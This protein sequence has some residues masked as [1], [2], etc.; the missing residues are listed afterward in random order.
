MASSIVHHLEPS[1]DSVGHLSKID[2]LCECIIW[3]PKGCKHLVRTA[4]AKRV[5]RVFGALPQACAYSFLDAVFWDDDKQGISIS[6]STI[7][8][9]HQTPST[10]A[11]RDVVEFCSGIGVM[12]YGLEQAGAKIQVRN[13]IRSPLVEFQLNEGTKHVIEGDIGDNRT[14]QKIFDIHS[15]SA[16]LTCGFSC[17]PWSALG[18]QRKFG[19]HRAQTLI[20]T[21]RAAYF[22]RSAGVILEC[23]TGSGKDPDVQQ[24]IRDWC[25]ATGFWFTDCVLNLE[26]FWVARRERWWCLLSSPCIP[27][28]E[29]KSLPRQIRAPV[30]ADFLPIF[31]SWPDEQLQQ[32]LVDEYEYGCFDRFGGLH[33]VLIDLHK[34]LS[35]ALHGWGNQLTGCPCSCRKGPMSLQRLSSK[36]L[37]GALL[38]CDGTMTVQNEKV[39]CVRHIHPWECAILNGAKPDRP[40]LI[41]LKLGLCGLGQMAS[42][43]HSG[44]VF[45][46]W[47][48]QV[49][50]TWNEPDAILPEQVL[51]AL[52]GKAVSARE[53]MFPHLL[54]TK[55][56]PR[57]SEFI[58]ATHRMLFQSRS[59]TNTPLS[60][61]QPSISP[62]EIP[63]QQL[64]HDESV[65]S[66]TIVDD[67]YGDVEDW[68]C[69]Y[70]LCFICRPFVGDTGLEDQ[71]HS[72]LIDAIQGS[73]QDEISPTIPFVVH[74][75]TPETLLPAISEE[76]GI[77]G[78]SRKRDHASAFPSDTH[79]DTPQSSIVSKAPVK[80]TYNPDPPK[81]N[82][83]S[84]A[85]PVP[86]SFTHSQPVLPG[87]PA[88][89]PTADPEPTD[90]SA[91]AEISDNESPPSIEG[92]SC[93]TGSM[94]NCKMIQLLEQLPKHGDITDSGDDCTHD[95]HHV[96]MHFPDVSNPLIVKVS[97][98]TTI[99][100]IVV[101]QCSLAQMQDTARSVRVMDCLGQLLPWSKTSYPMQHIF[102]CPTSNYRPHGCFQ[103]SGP[104][105]WFRHGDQ[106][107]R[108]QMLYR[109][110]SWVAHDEMSF[111][112][113]LL[114]YQNEC[115]SHAPLVFTGLPGQFHQWVSNCLGI[116]VEWVV[117]AIL[118]DHHWI[119]VVFQKTHDDAIQ[120]FTTREGFQLFRC[121]YQIPDKMQVQVITMPSLFSADCGFQTVGWILKI[122]TVPEVRFR[123][124]IV[125]S[126]ISPLTIKEAVTLRT[127]FEH[128]LWATPSAQQ[129]V[130]PKQ[131]ALGGALRESVEQSLQ[132]LLK[133][134][135]VPSDAL[136]SRVEVVL[137]KLG[138][139]SVSKAVR[140]AKSWAELKHLANNV[141]PR[142]QLVL[143]SELA[144]VVRERVEKGKPFGDKQRKHQVGSKASEPLQLNPEDI[145]IPEGIFK[146]GQDQVIR[147]IA[148]GSLCKD[149]QGIVVVTSTQAQPYLRLQQPMS[150]AGLAMLI[151][152]HADPSCIGSGCLVR[153]PAKFEST[154]EPLIATARIVQLGC[155]EIS[156]HLP[157]QQLKVDEVP[158]SVIRVLCFRDEFPGEWNDFIGHPVKF[159]MDNTEAF[160]TKTASESTVIDVWD[161]Q[162]VNHRMERRQPKH[163]DTFLVSI[164][165]TGIQIES[166]LTKSGQM[167]LYYEPRSSDGRSPHES[168]RVV[169]L[170]KTAKPDAL[171]SQQTSE[172]WSCLARNG[173][174]FGLRIRDV[175]AKE[176]HD[177]YKP[178]VPYLDGTSLNTF[179]VG[180][181]GFGVTKQGLVKLFAQWKW[182]ARPCQPRGKSTDG[183][184][185]L[186]E[187][188]AQERPAFE[189]YTLEHGDVLIS[190]V[191]KKK[192][193]VKPKSDI[194]APTR[195]L[196]VL[197][198]RTV[199]GKDSSSQ[200][201]DGLQKNDPW[202]SFVPSSKVQ[203][204]A[205]TLID[206][207][208]ATAQV[209]AI[210][211]NV[212]KK[213][214]A[215]LAQFEQKMLEPRDAAMDT[216]GLT[217]L[218][219]LEHRMNA[220]ES[221]MQCQQAQHQQHQNHVA[222]QFTQLQ[223][224][225]DAQGH[226]LQRHLDEK[227][228]E[229]LGQIERLL[230]RGDKKARQE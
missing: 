167:G 128:Q 213:V 148:L 76:G 181:F 111:Y 4:L 140:S 154:G 177:H 17:Q 223:Q 87:S 35:T 84:G 46:Q 72:S 143:P 214:A 165:V 53:K 125:G 149:A 99:G 138:R 34:P 227:M 30:V 100:Q 206:A 16:I 9:A 199:S 145:T 178:F 202:A 81:D 216:P 144:Q 42:P 151:L 94:V 182:A 207:R 18:D 133:S 162:F 43:F 104:P 130:I 116:Q 32:L 67:G 112:L 27:K 150:Q 8:L 103:Q 122:L 22:F 194:L 79:R 166:V 102:V 187:V 107:S 170:P 82:D 171:T 11:F 19:D 137:E 192:P 201:E 226:S 189:V 44:W 28:F 209:D 97:K 221:T 63:S 185:M 110:E 183:A 193:P 83:L 168:Y 20:H 200:S 222:A 215:T 196:D 188:Q 218:D 66:P 118:A 47:M 208:H 109:Q 224:Q 71:S 152:D 93:T 69:P 229:Q 156:R 117:S 55:Y 62:S 37:F 14:L 108:I 159:I 124:C 24:I 146:M 90:V 23:V 15:A 179:V 64:D 29:L 91:S 88:P 186:W 51:W 61:Q 157:A 25:K 220:I 56:G 230:G 115:A 203:R 60:L 212:D 41:N 38:P 228:Q 77:P 21:L 191:D 198:A 49:N 3:D 113:A 85:I 131:I 155:V 121:E 6:E 2:T 7:V 50:Q 78:F 59:E 195:T 40:W 68:D 197:K 163:A 141:S 106:C 204:V 135:G 142:L 211:A 158:T 45:G 160:M 73:V 101:T 129:T 164:R 36:G 175:D 126:P 57:L 98:T 52:V 120:I 153:F 119:P 65:H 31:P 74:T 33:S 89:I 48:Y 225:V 127:L 134:H 96:V 173:A 92:V 219:E 12:S 13:D 75:E 123:S 58:D 161:R 5:F 105:N 190:M 95:I 180:P 10:D 139:A 26:H 114:T 86:G 70:P 80:S 210:Q 1:W 132:D 174:K 184:G 172:Q 169:W 205:P 147:Q 136:E 176:V 217:R 54:Y 39:Q